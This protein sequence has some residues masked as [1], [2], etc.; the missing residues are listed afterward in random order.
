MKF[1]ITKDYS[2][3][4][5]DREFIINKSEKYTH[6][7]NGVIK[8]YEREVYYFCSA[9]IKVR[10][11]WKLDN[12]L[13]IISDTDSIQYRPKAIYLNSKG[14]YYKNG[15][16]IYLTEDE[17]NEMLDFSWKAYKFLRNI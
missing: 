6:N 2:R 7:Y 3:N 17:V 4:N 9:I 14:Y 8:E 16:V 5:D 12:E 11:D 10:E 1:I 15:K 13:S